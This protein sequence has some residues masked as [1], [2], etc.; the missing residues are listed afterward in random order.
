MRPFVIITVQTE[1]NEFNYDIEAPTDLQV[2]QLKEDIFETLC[3]YNPKQKT[4][5]SPSKL[6]CRRLKRNLNDN[7]TFGNAG[8]W[9]GD[10]IVLR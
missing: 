8:I 1:N 4:I 3:N 7:E 9:S 5:E 2:S 6:Y 10:I